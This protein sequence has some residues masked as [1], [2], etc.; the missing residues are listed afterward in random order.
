MKINLSSL[1]CLIDEN[2]RQY[3]SLFFALKKHVLN[4]S[5]QEL[6][7]TTNIVEDN[8]K[9]FQEEL[10]EVE[11]LSKEITKLKSILYEKNNSFK[12]S[13]GRTI[14][15]AIVENSNL[16]KLK[17]NLQTLL[18]YRNLKQR[19]TEVNNSY[20]QIQEINYNQ[21]EIK[22]QIQQLDL[23]IRNTDFEISK[24]NSIEFDIDL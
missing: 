14:Q 4:T 19:V 11:R 22:S 21:E 9:D 17:D 5:I 3:S 1:M 12:L 13:D 16:R 2:E 8:K 23:K 10:A 20:F 7:G 24:L 6:N 18:N 15:S